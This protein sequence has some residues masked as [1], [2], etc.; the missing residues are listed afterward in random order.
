LQVTFGYGAGQ[1]ENALYGCEG[2]FISSEAIPFQSAGMLAEYWSSSALRLSLSGGGAWLDGTSYG[3]VGGQAAYEGA[4]FGFGIGAVRTPFPD[5]PPFSPSI[6]LRIGNVE[7][8]HFRMD[9]YYPSY[10][11]GMTGDAFRIGMGANRRSQRGVSSFFGLSGTPY[12][13]AEMGGMVFGPFG[14]FTVPLSG[15]NA[16]SFAFRLRPWEEHVD[17]AA[18]I[19]L[20][21]RF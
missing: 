15:R 6:Y 18:G 8:I 11:L 10:G 12:S 4:G 1:F 14:E 13:I 19:G 2:D 7:N 5:S 20:R 16:L 9:S 17:A 3:M 21:Y